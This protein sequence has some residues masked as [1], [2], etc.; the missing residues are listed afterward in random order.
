VK[1]IDLYCKLEGH[2]GIAYFDNLSVYQEEFKQYVK[3]PSFEAPDSQDS[4]LASFW[5]P[6]GQGYVTTHA[7]HYG[8]GLTSIVT[9][10]KSAEDSK[11]ALQ[12]RER[13]TD[14]FF[15]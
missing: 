10:N 8:Y 3:N 13:K 4:K 2:Q 15:F 7:D 12:V 11:G 1:E 6:E 14:F 9:T 5:K